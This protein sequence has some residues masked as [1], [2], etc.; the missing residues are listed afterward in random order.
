M[1]WQLYFI[2][3]GKLSGILSQ[4][5]LFDG[6]E[7]GNKFPHCLTVTFPSSLLWEQTV[8][9]RVPIDRDAAVMG[10]FKPTH[11]KNSCFVKDKQKLIR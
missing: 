4:F 9:F 5:G 10:S 6:M 7:T 2:G 1:I 11:S 3:L 8:D